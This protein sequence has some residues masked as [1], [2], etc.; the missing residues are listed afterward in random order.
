M[1]HWNTQ[2][3]FKGGTIKIGSEYFTYTGV[4]G[5]TL[6]GVTRAQEGST[7]GDAMSSSGTITVEDTTAY[8]SVGAIQIGNELFTYTGTGTFTGVTRATSGT[9]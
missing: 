9:T 8:D 7:C 2:N 4:S 1:E 5:N 6:T 3:I